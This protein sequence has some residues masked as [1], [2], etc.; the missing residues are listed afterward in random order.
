LFI[1]VIIL[2]I[3]LLLLI[4]IITNY[5][6]KIEKFTSDIVYVN[7]AGL[8]GKYCKTCTKCP[9]N[10]VSINSSCLNPESLANVCRQVGR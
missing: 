3:S 2:I 9:S 1:F 5:F 7:S 8:T 6:N 4:T 10:T